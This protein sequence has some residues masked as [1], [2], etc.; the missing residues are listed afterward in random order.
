MLTEER[1]RERIEKLVKHGTNAED[2][3]ELAALMYVQRHEPHVHREFTEEIAEAWVERL[4]NTDPAK[5]HGGKWS[6]EQIK[7]VAQKYGIPTE[8]EKFWEFYAV[9]NMLYSDY[10][11]VAKKYN[12][13]NADFFSDMAMAFISDKDAVENKVAAYYEAV[14][15][16]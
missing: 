6:A 11:G 10:Y 14:V 12:A 4:E 9:M 5:P 3:M 16:K 13:L 15:E 7:P 2:A 1:I 8:G